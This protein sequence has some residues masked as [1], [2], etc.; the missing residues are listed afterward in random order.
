MTIAYH[1][2]LEEMREL[3]AIVQQIQEGQSTS[4]YSMK[5]GYFNER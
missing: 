3:Y 2:D 4:Q 1:R 5:Y